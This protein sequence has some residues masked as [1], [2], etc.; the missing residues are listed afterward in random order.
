V[1]DVALAHVRALD[2]PRGTYT[3]AAL[4]TYTPQELADRWSVRAPELQETPNAEPRYLVPQVPGWEP[5]VDVL[6]HIAATI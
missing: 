5:T 3:A 2:A 6:E 1:T 4:R